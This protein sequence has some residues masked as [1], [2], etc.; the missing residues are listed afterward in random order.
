MFY[1]WF[2]PIFIV[3]AALLMSFYRGVQKR[4]IG[5]QTDGKTV[6]DKSAR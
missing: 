1:L 4:N 3:L 6:V 5:K 2:I